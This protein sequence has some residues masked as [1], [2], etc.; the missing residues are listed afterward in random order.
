MMGNTN[1]FFQNS[2]T[3]NNQ[4]VYLLTYASFS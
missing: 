2:L 4:M 1:F 3:S